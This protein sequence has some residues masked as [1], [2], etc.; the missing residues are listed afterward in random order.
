MNRPMSQHGITRGRYLWLV[1]TVALGL[2]WSTQ[3]AAAK[4]C[5]R[6]TPLPADVRLIAPTPEVPEAV[7]RFAGVWV[8][9]LRPD[10]ILGAIC[11]L[12]RV[13]IGRERFALCHILVVEEV[14]ANGIARV[15]FSLG[16]DYADSYLHLPHV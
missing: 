2:A 7:A 4:G 9:A 1:I 5:H 6:E 12:G 8:G 15:V 3:A 11:Q 14:Y 13:L 16:T 10:G